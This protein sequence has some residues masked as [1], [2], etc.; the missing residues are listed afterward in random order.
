MTNKTKRRGLLAL[1]LLLVI[2]ITAGSFAAW[3]GANNRRG[4]DDFHLGRID[5]INM[6][7]A[8]EVTITGGALFPITQPQIDID[9]FAGP[10]ARELAVAVNMDNASVE[11][12]LLA[13]VVIDGARTLAAGSSLWLVEETAF[14]ALDTARPAWGTDAGAAALATT[15]MAGI[16]GAHQLTILANGTVDPTVIVS[17]DNARIAV[18]AGPVAINFR[19]VLVSGNVADMDMQFTLH[20]LAAPTPVI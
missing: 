12:D 13:G 16:T 20:F 15:G 9:A 4:D 11:F 3:I 19:L 17:A 7:G 18:G 8:G 1:C 5:F 14:T 2:G 6:V 10:A